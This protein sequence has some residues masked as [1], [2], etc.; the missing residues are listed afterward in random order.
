MGEAP[1]RPS[2]ITQR[3]GKFPSRY[4]SA[5]F[6]CA[7]TRAHVKLACCVNE[8]R[9][10]AAGYK[11]GDRIATCDE[12]EPDT[13]FGKP[14]QLLSGGNYNTQICWPAFGDADG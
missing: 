10:T 9:A 6:C 4:M 2:V 5:A 11:G 12:E 8:T 14:G 7:S 13:F 1:R 3:Q